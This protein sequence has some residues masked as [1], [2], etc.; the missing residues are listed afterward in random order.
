M[1]ALGG[2]AVLLPSEILVAG[3]NGHPVDFMPLRGGRLV[4]VEELAEGRALASK[5]CKILA[6]TPEITAR[7]LYQAPVTF[8]AQH[9]PFIN[10][11]HLP[12]LDEADHGTRRRFQMVPFDTRYI[13]S[14]AERVSPSDRIGDP[15]LKSRLRGREQ[16]QAVLAWIVQGAVRYAEMGKT[17]P[18]PPE[19]V[20]ARTREWVH[21]IDPL[22][23]YIEDHLTFDP[24]AVISCADLL[25]HFNQCTGEGWKNW[26]AETFSQRFRGHNLVLPHKV[27][28]SRA[29]ASQITNQPPGRLPGSRQGQVRVWRGVRWV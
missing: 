19:A 24:D 29:R 8:R 28:K 20:K 9:S 15:T 2:Y 18:P 6:G 22:Q 14:E 12:I 13:K 27:T 21:E 5:Q 11:N 7:N 17:L 26:G 1:A 4:V 23:V 3:R 16:Q 10:T 25:E